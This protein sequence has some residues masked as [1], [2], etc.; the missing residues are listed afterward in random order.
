MDI[1]KKLE[2]SC[3]DLRKKM[4][5][6][7]LQ[8]QACKIQNQINAAINNVETMTKE[9]EDI[10]NVLHKLE[11]INTNTK[12]GYT[13]IKSFL[14]GD[15]YI[16]DRKSI[17]E[18]N[19]KPINYKS[20]NTSKEMLE[21]MMEEF[22]QVDELEK[23]RTNIEEKQ[24]PDLSDNTEIWDRIYKAQQNADIL[25]KTSKNNYLFAIDEDKFY[26]KNK[27]QDYR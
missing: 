20:C 15:S 24:L 3:E 9:Y 13:D 1:D 26:K 18:K 16:N 5:I 2:D 10:I 12:K 21:S 25:E 11:F 17:K 23:K 6:E 8:S 14:I 22:H 4:K 7:I 27:E 19:T